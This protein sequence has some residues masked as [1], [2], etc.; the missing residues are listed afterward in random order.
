MPQPLNSR[1]RLLFTFL[2]LPFLLAALLY[3][4]G[5][6]S[7]LLDNYQVWTAAG[8]TPGYRTACRS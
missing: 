5:F 4:G 8:G 1:L 2:P 3:A 7:Q 6:I